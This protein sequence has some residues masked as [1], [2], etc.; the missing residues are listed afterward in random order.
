[1]YVKI[2]KDSFLIAIFVALSMSILI[3]CTKG[4]GTIK[5]GSK[6]NTPTKMSMIYDGFN[7]HKETQ[8]KV[9]EGKL[10]RQNLSSR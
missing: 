7:G 1:M 10:H 2:R 8:I 4:S 9:I 6:L 3:G 5:I